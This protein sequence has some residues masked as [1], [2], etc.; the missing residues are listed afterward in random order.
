MSH[1]RI[2]PSGVGLPPGVG[3]P[4]GVGTLPSGVGHFRQEHEICDTHIKA[5]IHVM[6]RQR[7][8]RSRFALNIRVNIGWRATSCF[9]KHKT[10]R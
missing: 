8:V 7:I 3:L 4:S 10:V 1:R 5:S 6:S 2:V 9:F